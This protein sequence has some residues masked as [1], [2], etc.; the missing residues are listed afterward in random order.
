VS[1]LNDKTK[2]LLEKVDELKKAKAYSFFRPQE[3]VGVRVKVG[4][5][6]YVNFT[7]NDYLG[8]SRDPRVMRAAIRGIVQ[9]GTGLG[10]ARPQATS[11]RHDELERRLARWLGYPACVTFTTGYQSLVG[12]LS[13]FL[14]DDVTLILDR[15]SHASIM[16][17]MLLARGEHPELEVRS[18]KH[19]NMTQLRRCL[20]TAEHKKKMVVVEGYYSVDGDLGKI[21]EIV[22]LCRELDAVLMVD[23]AHGLGA[24][25]ATG[26]G[27]GE[28]FGVKDQIDIL[29]GT[30]SKAF[31]GIGGFVCAS[32][33]LID[34]MKLKARAFMFSASLPV[35]QVEAAITALEIIQT[36]P[37]HIRRLR[38]NGDFFRQGLTELGFDL[39]DSIGHIT[40]IMLRDQT[41][42]LKFGAYLFHGGD[43]MMMP[44]ISPGVPPGTERLRCNITAAHTRAEMSY[45][46]EALAKIG[47]MLEVLPKGTRTRASNL[48][49]SYWFAGHKLRGLRNAGL[50]FMVKELTEVGKKATEWTRH[51]L[52][53]KNHDPSHG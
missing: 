48:Q 41:L 43:V 28:L 29:I 7:S 44:F 53:G 45:A 36:E 4:T 17:G 5:G 35:S 21:D 18:F 46:L 50:P 16:E 2:E 34:Y 27:V 31:G 25:G 10:S 6:S 52:G 14:D 30:F 47:E 19:N 24:L 40:P 1:W 32:Q 8:L 3:N 13:A 42:T 22:A 39:G 49:R 51:Q 9:Y 15:L 12:T 38:E 23:D 11:V 26:R 33:D 37:Q 20:E